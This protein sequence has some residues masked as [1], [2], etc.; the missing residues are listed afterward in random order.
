MEISGC[1][2]QEKRKHTKQE[3]L[4]VSAKENLFSSCKS[5]FYG[6]CTRSNIILLSNYKHTYFLLFLKHDLGLT[7]L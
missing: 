4:E 6:A 7:A 5:L 3:Q 2:N 1:G